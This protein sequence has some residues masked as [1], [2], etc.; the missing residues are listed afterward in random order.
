MRQFFLLL[1]IAVQMKA[2]VITVAAAANIGYAIKPLVHE[3]NKIYPDIDVRVILGSSGKL[4]AQIRNKAPFDIFLSADVAYPQSLYERGYTLVEPVVY[5][6]GVLVLFSKHKRDFSK[7]LKLLKE[8][9]IKRIAMANPKTAP[10]GKAAK[11]A[12]QKSG[13]YEVVRE[14]IIYAESVSQT[15]TYALK[16]AD[17]GIVAKS[18][19]FWPAMQHFRKGENWE[20]VN[21][22][23]YT[24][25]KQAMVL[26]KHAKENKAA[27]AFFN[28]MRSQE[29]KRVLLA[30]GYGVE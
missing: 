26:L 16:A 4:S 25:I 19:L 13:V 12:L 10:Y 23:L 5:A 24:P 20:E 15:L 6:Q 2:A 17:V 29:A 1:I 28:F 7:G 22:R 3:F 18:A 14:K 21:M 11:E 9:K 30:Y 8:R 27:Y